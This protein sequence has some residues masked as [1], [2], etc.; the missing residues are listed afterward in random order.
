MNTIKFTIHGK[1]IAKARHRMGNGFSYDPQSKIKNNHKTIIA[2]GMR[3][4][5]LKPLQG[6]IGASLVIN[7]GLPKS[8]SKKK[9]KALL[10][11]FVTSRPDNDNYEKF[12]FDVMNEIAYKDD[13][14]IALNRCRKVYAEKPSVNIELYSL[15]DNIMVNEH[16]ITY[17]ESLSI[18]D[19]NYLIKK[20]NT[21]G[22][23]S[24]QVIRVFQEE[25]S[26]GKH[27]YFE[28][29]AMRGFKDAN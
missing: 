14:L 13:C 29:E 28:V 6:A 1:P 20:A 2:Q 25:D 21:L 5:S 23:T 4:H 12:Y 7:V 24:R 10:G 15:E 9:R 26:E 17:K 27:L 18:D 19:L 3:E 16:A 22:L 8:W 11:Q